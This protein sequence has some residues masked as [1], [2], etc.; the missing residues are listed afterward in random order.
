[1]KLSIITVNLNNAAGLQKTI[2][3]I[4]SQSYRDFEWIVIDGGSNDGSLDLISQYSDRMSYWISEPDSGIYNAMNKG[5]IKANG[6]YCFFLNS[7]DYFVNENSLSVFF[8]NDFSEDVVMGN[9]FVC[10]NGKVI[11]KC[12]GKEKLT[13]IDLY[14]SIIKHQSTFIRLELLRKY[15]MYDETL[16]IVADYEFFLKA[17]GLGNASYKYIDSNIA[18]FDNN[19]ISNNNP[20]LVLQEK[21]GVI[22]KYLPNLMQPDYE[23]FVKNRDYEIVLKYKVPKIFIRLLAKTVRVFEKILKI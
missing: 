11:G 22:N 20:N 17:V 18:Y 14:D 5:I 8:S 16:K 19:G 10:L 4:I 15:G 23:F 3:S 12:R 9:M 13:F 6:E 2:E 7:G 1:M 21:K